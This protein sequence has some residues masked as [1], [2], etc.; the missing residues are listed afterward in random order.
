MLEAEKEKVKEHYSKK[1]VVVNF[2]SKRYEGWSGRY[3]YEFKEKIILEK[4]QGQKGQ[5]ILDIGMGTGRLYKNI[6][7]LGYNYIGFNFSFEMVAEAKR[8]Y[9]G[10]NNFFVCDAFRLALKDNSI[11]FSV[12]VGLLEMWTALSLF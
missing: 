6:V 3:F 12:C 5:A 9:D 4:L 7:R 11:Q 10:N 8:K 2:S 1:S